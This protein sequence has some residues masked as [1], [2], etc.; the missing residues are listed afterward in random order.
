M[1]TERP[2]FLKSLR[3][4]E[5]TLTHDFSTFGKNPDP[6][7]ETYNSKNTYSPIKIKYLLEFSCLAPKL[8]RKQWMDDKG[9]AFFLARRHGRE[10]EA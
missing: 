3:T 1:E 2:G 10:R 9:I 5:Q 6:I 4:E 8:Q 7:S